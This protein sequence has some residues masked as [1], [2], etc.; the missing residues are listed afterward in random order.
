MD[1][2]LRNDDCSIHPPTTNLC[3]ER[4][5][6]DIPACI[7]IHSQPT[8]HRTVAIHSLDTGIAELIHDKKSHDQLYDPEITVEMID[9]CL[10]NMQTILCAC[11]KNRK[12]INAI[13]TSENK[14]LNQCTKNKTCDR[15]THDLTKTNLWPA[16]KKH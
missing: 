12:K 15:I 10:Q 11:H 5:I 4:K 8:P 1:H 2:I 9:C 7:Q 3:F 14:S 16:N 13:T 6:H